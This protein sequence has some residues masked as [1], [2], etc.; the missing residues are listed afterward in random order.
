M[1]IAFRT[2]ASSQIGTGHAMRCLTLADALR[3]QDA[4][5]QFVCREHEGHLMG[6]IRSRGHDTHALPR[7]RPSSSFESDLAHA[8]WLGVDWQTD[9]AQTRQA[10]GNAALDWLI[11]DHYALDRPWE[12][13]LRSSC[14]RI[15]VIDDLADRQHDCDLLLDQNYGSSAERYRAYGSSEYSAAC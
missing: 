11:V 1:R 9:A 14:K 8:S 3:E 7:T 5:C 15:M 6:Y 12:S 4:E 13:A 10:L 2:D